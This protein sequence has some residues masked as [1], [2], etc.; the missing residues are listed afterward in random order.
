MTASVGGQVGQ[1][2]ERKRAE[3]AR[4]VSEARKAAVLE[5]APDVIVTLNQG[6]RIVE[7]NPAVETV[8][9]YTRDELVGEAPRTDSS[10]RPYGSDMRGGSPVTWRRG[11]RPSS[12]GG[13]SWKDFART[14]P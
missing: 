7:V 1:F 8:F 14:A 12:T 13:S 5:S 6:G 4:R 9:G 11:R 2:I 3:E 10:P